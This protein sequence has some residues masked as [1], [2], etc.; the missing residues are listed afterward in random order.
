M[1]GPALVPLPSP[2][3]AGGEPFYVTGEDALRLTAFNSAAG[4]TLSVFGR[5]LP[6]KQRD[7]EDDPRPTPFRV[8]LIPTTNRVASSRLM[9]LGE[10]WLLDWLVTVT[11]GTPSHGQCY[12]KVQLV[13]GTAG[14]TQALATIAQGYV[15][16]SQDV[17]PLGVGASGFT[18]GA[19]ALRNISGTTPAAGA[20]IGEAVPTNTRWEVLSFRCVFTASAAVANRNPRLLADDGVGNVY[21]DVELSQ[22]IA[23]NVT[24]TVMWAPYLAGQ[25]QGANNRFHNGFPAVRLPPAHRL[26]TLT[27][28]IQAADQYS[29]VQFLVREWIEGN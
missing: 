10:G 16:T 29:S 23:A 13:R 14:A 17:G 22:N 27:T 19:G 24:G 25:A 20:E 2:A 1:D 8:D 9:S 7:D 21:A 15:T 12:V 4:I 5:F 18:D 26:R 11:A 28:G 3:L 6:I